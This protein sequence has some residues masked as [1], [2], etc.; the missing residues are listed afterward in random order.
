LWKDLWK[1][2]LKHQICPFGR[3]DLSERACEH[4][5]KFTN[6][7]S[8]ERA[9][10]PQVMFIDDIDE[11]PNTEV[12]ESGQIWELFKKLRKFGMRNDQIGILVRKFGKDMTRREIMEDMG[13]TSNKMFEIRYNQAIDALRKRG[14]R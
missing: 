6:Y 4:L 14:F 10:K 11:K 12:Q 5:N 2:A 1:V 8:S 7:D 13:W 9:I 3:C